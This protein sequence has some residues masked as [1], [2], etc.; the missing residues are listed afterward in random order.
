MSGVLNAKVTKENNKNFFSK[1]Q[2]W[3]KRAKERK[4]IKKRT[5]EQGKK[6]LS[7]F[8]SMLVEF[9]QDRE[10]IQNCLTDYHNLVDDLRTT[11]K[12]EKVCNDYLAQLPQ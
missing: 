8:D 11:R 7:E 6:I 5:F 4:L 10:V 12:I 9:S 1:C 3:A 2:A